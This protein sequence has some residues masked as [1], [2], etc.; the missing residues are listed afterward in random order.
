MGTGSGPIQA[1]LNGRIFWDQA[2]GKL[3]IKDENGTQRLLASAE[4]IRLSQSGFNVETAT[5][6]Q[7]I[8][9]SE[10]NLFKIAATGTAQV[11]VAAIN[12]SAVGAY[13]ES[14]TT[15]IPHNLGYI[16]A[17][18]VF[19]QSDTGYSNANTPVI[20]SAWGSGGNSARGDTIIE[21]YS[22]ID[23]LYVRIASR[24]NIFSAVS[25]NHPGGTFDVKY[26]L[27]QETAS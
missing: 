4:S 24:L 3:V 20:R 1:N 11:T 27:L 13:K 23:N 26:Y 21:P 15:T 17:F 12:Q 5:D 22:D 7:L 25:A 18:L 16:P 19:Y 14:D 2:R 10:F 6:S 8:F 9:S